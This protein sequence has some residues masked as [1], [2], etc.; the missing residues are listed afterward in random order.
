MIDGNGNVTPNSGLL[1]TYALKFK[2]T[3]DE[4]EIED[5]M[6]LVPAKEHSSISHILDIYSKAAK[7]H[8]NE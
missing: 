5:A 6:E 8:N 3:S 4:K 2:D 1:N 7:R